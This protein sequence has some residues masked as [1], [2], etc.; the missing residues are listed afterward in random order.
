MRSLFEIDTKDYDINGTTVSRPSA[1]G[2]IIKDGKLAMIHSIKY[3]Y[4]KFPGGG[5]EKNE[6]KESALIREVLEE[7]GLDVIPQ[8]IKEYGMVHRI[9]KGDYED[10][11]IQDNFYY[12]CDVE[13]NVHEQKLDDYEKE[14]KFT[15]EY[16]SPKQVIDANK[17]CAS[18]EADQ[19]MLERE[20][21]VI[22]ILAQEGYI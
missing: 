14:E 22:G 6:Q 21:K 19:I 3:D 18:K 1:R 12:L 5:I 2:I 16:V 17:A 15:L 11:F 20:C 4:Y 13:D 7:T 9:Q 10:V 8:T